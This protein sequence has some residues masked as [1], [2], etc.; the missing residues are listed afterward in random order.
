MLFVVVMLFFIFYW[1]QNKWFLHFQWHT[2]YSYEVGYQN[3]PSI[4][5]CSGPLCHILQTNMAPQF[6]SLQRC[7]FVVCILKT[8]PN[9]RRVWSSATSQQRCGMRGEC[10][11]KACSSLPSWWPETPFARESRLKCKMSTRQTRSDGS[12]KYL[13]LEEERCIYTFKIFCGGKGS[14]T[15][16]G[17]FLTTVV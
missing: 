16:L 15:I 12:S 4:C 14:F 10:Q 13:H 7:A 8:N 5:S 2:L 17:S 9:R 11:A 6:N 1:Y 3:T